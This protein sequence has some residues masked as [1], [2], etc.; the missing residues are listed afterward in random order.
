MCK[1]GRDFQPGRKLGGTGTGR[2][3][4]SP[5]PD[6]LSDF[7]PLGQGR[8]LNLNQGDAVIM[9]KPVKLHFFPGV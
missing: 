8:V 6:L 4:V 2:L 3:L 9:G 5:V 1:Q 7:T